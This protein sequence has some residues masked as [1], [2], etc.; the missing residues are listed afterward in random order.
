MTDDIDGAIDYLNT[1]Q[2]GND[3][4]IMEHIAEVLVKL[5]DY[6]ADR[7]IDYFEPFSY[8][9]KEERQNA[10]DTE[11][12]K[13]LVFNEKL[14]PNFVEIGKI[15]SR[16]RTNL[17]PKQ[18]LTAEGEEED[19][20][21]QQEGENEGDGE[22]AEK[23]EE[24]TVNENGEYPNLVSDMEWMNQVGVG[25]TRDETELLQLALHKLIQ[26]NPLDNARFWGKI[27][28]IQGDYYI[29]EVTYSA[30]SRPSAE[31]PQEEEDKGEE[32]KEKE[33]K[34]PLAPME[35]DS[36]PNTFCYFV[37]TALGKRWVRLPDIKPHQI[38]QSRSIRQRFSGNLST[39]VLAPPGRFDGNEGT[40]L[41]A[42]IARMYH[43]TTLAPKGKYVP[44][45]GYP[46]EED[47][48]LA[49][50]AAL[51]EVEEW[52]GKPINNPLTGFVHRV[53]YLLPQGRTEEWVPETEEEQDEEKKPTGPVYPSILRPI[54]EDEPV[55]NHPKPQLPEGQEPE[56]IPE[57]IKAQSF[58][59]FQIP[60]WTVRTE[61]LPKKGQK[62]FWLRS[63]TWPGMNILSSETGDK[64]V[65]MYFGDGLKVEPPLD[66]PPAWKPKP[67]PAPPKE[68]EE[69]EE[70][71]AK[72][73]ENND[74][75]NQDE[76]AEKPESES[77]TAT[78]TYDSGYTD[79]NA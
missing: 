71:E 57:N 40:L 47:Q 44:E 14:G 73:E 30:D 17:F 68:E 75:E 21:P 37:C 51:T 69:K 22:E 41:R 65:Q 56:D 26:T 64:M 50:N 66:W 45:E 74:Q 31:A 54:G 49:S 62:L 70:E 33:E 76:N 10:N 5:T 24:E 3:V 29:A 67:K 78:G 35:E 27:N 19:E 42:T 52:S 16:L 38:A 2:E 48:R 72:N 8:I 20:E 60:S 59:G 28:T 9:V 53:P 79:S 39:P 7:P 55:G 4:S 46:E 43:S 12:E 15:T 58:D 23:P 34:E 25:L 13:K 36:G 63:N 11:P 18:K 6:G 32:P 61:K 1:K 77:E